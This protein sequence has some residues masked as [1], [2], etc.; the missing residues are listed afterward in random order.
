MWRGEPTA[1]AFAAE[2]QT[3]TDAT[4]FHPDVRVFVGDNPAS[5]LVH[6]RRRRSPLRW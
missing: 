6:M 1:A 3:D 5:G 4:A 2:I